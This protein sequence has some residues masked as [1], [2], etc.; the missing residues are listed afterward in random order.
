MQGHG[1]GQITGVPPVGLFVA[2]ERYVRVEATA[3][4]PEVAEGDFAGLWVEV[5]SSLTNGELAALNERMGDFDR[6]IAEVKERYRNEFLALDDQ[7]ARAKQ[8][9]QP[10]E[11]VEATVK[12]SL[13]WNAVWRD[14]HRVERDRIA[15]LAPYV[16]AWNLPAPS[17]AEAGAEAFDALPVP[18]VSWLRRVVLNAY[19]EGKG[20]GSWRKQPPGSPGPMSESSTTTSA[21][22]DEDSL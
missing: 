10:S 12:S 13:L 5:R 17:P 19:R 1:K 7:I 16:R 6:A 2:A 8:E 15:L 22:G 9:H 4:D 21:G 3:D 14:I 18:A 20:L 11:V